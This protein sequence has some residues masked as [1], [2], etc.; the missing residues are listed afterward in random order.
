MIHDFCLASIADKKNQFGKQLSI[1]FCKNCV[2]FI[3]FLFFIDFVK[4]LG[5]VWCEEM[6]RLRCELNSLF[7]I[8]TSYVTIIG[9]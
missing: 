2:F 5:G 4:Y 6:R 7:G 8:P 3:Y 9:N 1:L